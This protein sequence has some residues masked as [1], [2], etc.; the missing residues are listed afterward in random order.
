MAFETG[1]PAEGGENVSVRPCLLPAVALLTLAVGAC[2]DQAPAATP[3]TSS[4]PPPVAG[5][6][7]DARDDLAARATLAL[8]KPYAALYSLDD[9]SGAR[10]VVAT[11]AA[12]GTWRVDV[13]RGVQGGTTDVSIVSL[14]TGVYQCTVATAA[15]PIT[16]ACTRVAEK[17]KRVP[18]K[19]SPRVERLFRP[20]L[21]AFTDRESGLTV[22]EVQPLPGAKG[23][24][25]SVDSISASLDAPVNVGIYCYA[26]DGVLTAARVGFGVLRLVSQVAGPPTVPLPGPDT[27]AIPMSTATPPPPAAQP[28]LPAPPA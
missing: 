2:G 23:T 10:D 28:S 27:G 11:T 15:N 20:A 21:T 14:P 9:G 3:A 5:N 6:G 4:P 17:G 13:S 19:Y 8:D 7:P 12:D 26:D 24:C 1:V 16:P 18:A 25:F 22:T